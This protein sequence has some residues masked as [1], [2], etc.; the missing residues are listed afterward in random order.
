M[1]WSAASTVLLERAFFAHWT[2]PSGHIHAGGL[3]ILMGLV[4]FPRA[5]FDRPQRAPG[6]S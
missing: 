5:F 3:I 6:A 2:V 1:N 4:E